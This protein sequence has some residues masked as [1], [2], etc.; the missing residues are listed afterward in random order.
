MVLLTAT[1]YLDIDKSLRRMKLGESSQCTF[2]AYE[3]A[4]AKCEEV[5]HMIGIYNLLHKKRHFEYL[6]R[7][8][9]ENSCTITFH[10]K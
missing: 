2:A 3:N 6:I 4:Q 1:T 5:A 8:V 9:N 10:L 7:K